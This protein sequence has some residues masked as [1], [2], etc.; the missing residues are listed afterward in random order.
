M[1]STGH[2][3]RPL[4]PRTPSMTRPEPFL[5][6]TT[7]NLESDANVNR[8]LAQ[9][10]N[11]KE[12]Q[13]QHTSFCRSACPPSTQQLRAQKLRRKVE[14]GERR[15]EAFP[16]CDHSRALDE[17]LDNEWKLNQP[18]REDRHRESQ[19]RTTTTLPSQ[20]PFL[21]SIDFDAH[22]AVDD[23]AMPVR[24]V[25]DLDLER[26]RDSPSARRSHRR[27]QGTCILVALLYYWSPVNDSPSIRKNLFVISPLVALMEEQAKDLASSEHEQNLKNNIGLAIDKLHAMEEWATDEFR[28]AYSELAMNLSVIKL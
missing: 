7:R 19:R 17:A 28:P 26:N 16:D 20:L 1:P 15:L 2:H 6:K 5:L 11:P 12:A 14:Q 27:R 22:S 3:L 23:D 21:D 13:L 25:L 9:A 10:L 8:N 4:L 24:P 18:R